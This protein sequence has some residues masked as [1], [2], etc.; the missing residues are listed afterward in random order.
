M[1]EQDLIHDLLRI[2]AEKNL[3]EFSG[4]PER[5]VFIRNLG[6]K[7]KEQMDPV[8]LRIGMS[9]V[10]V[11][12]VALM[13]LE[14]HKNIALYRHHE[15]YCVLYDTADEIDALGGGL[16][17]LEVIAILPPSCMSRT[18]MRRLLVK[19]NSAQNQQKLTNWKENIA[20]SQGMKLVG[21]TP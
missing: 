3:F 12:D 1:T 18:K 21:E 4:D 6:I 17:M 19:M 9:M 11:V 20:A 7:G 14:E 10:D 5:K 8:T 13:I 2:N 16:P 15:G